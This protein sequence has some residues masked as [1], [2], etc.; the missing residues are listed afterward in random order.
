MSLTLVR[1]LPGPAVTN[2]W[3][4]NTFRRPIACFSQIPHTTSQ[5]S[6]RSWCGLRCVISVKWGYPLPSFRLLGFKRPSI[7][8][9]GFRPFQELKGY[10][11][12]LHGGFLNLCGL[13][14]LSLVP[15]LLL[16]VAVL[17]TVLLACSITM[18]VWVALW[19]ILQS[20]LGF[21]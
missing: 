13:S 2:T 4:K 9:F 18:P 19:Q 17:E 7:A 15:G 12:T 3:L 14:C 20:V 21:V 11:Q 8:S 10:S 6:L 16:V 5:S 1:V